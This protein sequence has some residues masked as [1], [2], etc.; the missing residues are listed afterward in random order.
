MG[1]IICRICGEPWDAYGVRNGDMDGAEAKD[2]LAGRDCP[3]C[4]FGK[5]ATGRTH[6][7][8]FLS[9]LTEETDE[10]PIMLLNNVDP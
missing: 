2:F 7:D 9:N 3:C 8:Q 1:D 5:K 6:E 4:G 10:D